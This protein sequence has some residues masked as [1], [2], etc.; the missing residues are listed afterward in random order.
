MNR[1]LDNLYH[2]YALISLSTKTH[3]MSKLFGCLDIWI[4]LDI[5]ILMRNFHTTLCWPSRRLCYV[6]SLPLEECPMLRITGV[7]HFWEALPRSPAAKGCHE[8]LPPSTVAKC[9]REALLRSTAAKPCREA[10]P[11]NPAVKNSFGA[12]YP[13]ETGKFLFLNSELH[14]WQNLVCFLPNLAFLQ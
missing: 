1:Y 10:L 8:V 12:R 5:C 9:C 7:K 3:Y 11:Q 6:L 14:N 13:F 2:S 4:P